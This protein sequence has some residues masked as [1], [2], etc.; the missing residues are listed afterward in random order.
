MVIPQYAIHL[1][2]YEQSLHKSRRQWHKTHQSKEGGQQGSSWIL[3]TIPRHSKMLV[4]LKHG[5][6]LVL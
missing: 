2:Q 4:Q 1:N 3:G 5:F 6:Q